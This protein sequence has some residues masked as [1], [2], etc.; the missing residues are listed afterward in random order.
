MRAPFHPWNLKRDFETHADRSTQNGFWN[1]DTTAP[2][3]HPHRNG[4]HEVDRALGLDMG[5]GSGVWAFMLP[6]RGAAKS[7]PLTSTH[8]A[9]AIPKR[10]CR[11][12]ASSETAAF[13]VRE[14]GAGRLNDVATGHF[15]VVVANINRNILLEDMDA[16]CRVLGDIGNVDV[17]WLHGA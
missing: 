10:T 4:E 17:E 5:C 14:G 16:Y 7:W 2:P 3:W 11:S 6:I 1:W 15:D 8:G 9:C 13:E 12:T